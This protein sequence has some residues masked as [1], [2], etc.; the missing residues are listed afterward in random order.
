MVP[1]TMAAQIA[2]STP[3]PMTTALSPC[4]GCCTGSPTV[5]SATYQTLMTASGP[6]IHRHSVASTEAG[7]RVDRCLATALSD[8]SRS[9]IKLLIEQGNLRKVE[10]ADTANHGAGQT[11]NE[12]SYRVKPGEELELTIPAPEA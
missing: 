4:P 3:R 8:L 5:P 2:S 1:T 10:A 12:P 9:R 7:E 11:I 6:S